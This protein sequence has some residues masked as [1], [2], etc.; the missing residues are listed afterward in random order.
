M[1]CVDEQEMAHG[2]GP[3]SGMEAPWSVGQLSVWQRLI[4]FEGT[5]RQDI[6]DASDEM[7]SSLQ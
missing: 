1:E 5:A 2:P 6:I 7:S 4:E 3:E